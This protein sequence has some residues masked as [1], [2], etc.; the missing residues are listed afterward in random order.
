MALLDRITALFRRSPITY[1]PTTQ[2]TLQTT[3]MEPP[4]RPTAAFARYEVENTRRAIV[5][6]CQRMVEDDP[7]V[8]GVLAAVARDVMR[9][10]FELV[11]DGPRADEAKAIA[12]E[13]LNRVRFFKR[14]GGWILSSMRDGDTFL[15]LAVYRDWETDRK[16]TL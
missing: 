12:L 11:V 1:S 16:S 9:N 10:G 5:T 8:E 4:P 3:L 13:T 7:R 6:D 15:E 14:A 2:P